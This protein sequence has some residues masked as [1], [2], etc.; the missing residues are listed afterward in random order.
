MYY[1][2]TTSLYFCSSDAFYSDQPFE[3][4][5]AQ[6]VR[7]TA[8]DKYFGAHLPKCRYAWIAKGMTWAPTDRERFITPG[9]RVRPKF[10]TLS[11]WTACTVSGPP[12]LS[13]A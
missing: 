10:V 2:C 1:T 3:N 6:T 5:S 8:L 9:R 11:T 12:S 7:H 4:A 13:Q